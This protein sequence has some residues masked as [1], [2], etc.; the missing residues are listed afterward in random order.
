MDP[1]LAYIHTRIHLKHCV[2]ATQHTHD[3][4]Y[5]VKGLIPLFT[6]E[7]K[8]GNASLQA[9]FN[10][11]IPGMTH[12][13]NVYPQAHGMASTVKQVDFFWGR[14]VGPNG[15]KIEFR[16]MYL[17]FDRDSTANYTK[18]CITFIQH[19]SYLLLQDLNA[20]FGITPSQCTGVNPSLD[21]G[22]LIMGS[23]LL[24]VCTLGTM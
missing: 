3:Y 14:F 20:N 10:K 7:A 19:A 17:A 15:D 4:G 5:Y 1:F 12:T 6:G 21:L 13:M 18:S 16:K 22:T 8:S 23:P 24:P 9:E 11:Y 2:P